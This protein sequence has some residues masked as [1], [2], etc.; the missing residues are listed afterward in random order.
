[1]QRG[2]S[3]WKIAQSQLGSGNRYREIMTLNG[4]SS[5]VLT[6]G[7]VLRIP[8]GSGGGS[9]NPSTPSNPTPTYR[10]YTVQRGDSLWKIAQS[11]LGSGSR[12]REI[13]SLNN[14]K[15]ETVYPGQVLRLP[16]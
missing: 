8:S 12:Y 4:L 3:L 15:N 1:M 11:Q 16:K 6:P 5:D 13:I 7:Q 10:E 2:D 9:S 14:L